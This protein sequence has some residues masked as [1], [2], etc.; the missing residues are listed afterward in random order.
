VARLKLLKP[1]GLVLAAHHLL[2]SAQAV[3]SEA[4]LWGP[5]SSTLPPLALLKL[6]LHRWIQSRAQQQAQASEP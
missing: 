2:Q 3:S 5:P 1:G 4:G 6:F